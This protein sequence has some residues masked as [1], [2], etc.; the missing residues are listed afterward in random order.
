MC[1]SILAVMSRQSLIG[2]QQF[3]QPLMPSSVKPISDWGSVAVFFCI[4]NNPK[5]IGDEHEIK[6]GN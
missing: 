4:G 5:G 1:H 6:D 2:R 3:T